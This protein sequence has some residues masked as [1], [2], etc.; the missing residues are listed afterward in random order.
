MADTPTL[1]TKTTCVCAWP[2]GTSGLILVTFNTSCGLASVG[3]L[4]TVMARSGSSRGEHWAGTVPHGE[5]RDDKHALH[6]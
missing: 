6:Q 3:K 2:S 4:S 1:P 5:Q